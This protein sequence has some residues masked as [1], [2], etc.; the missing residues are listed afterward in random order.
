MGHAA[1]VMVVIDG[2][3]YVAIPEKDYVRMTGKSDP[4]E[5]AVDAVAFTRKAI[6]DDLRA[7][8][9]AAG[10]TQQQLAK[11]LRKTQPM[12]SGAETG[13][14]RVGLKYVQAVLRACGLPDDWKAPPR[15]KAVGRRPRREVVEFP[16]TARRT[17]RRRRARAPRFAA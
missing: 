17:P 5:G 16:R 15:A 7:A 2:E 9:E 8:R 10:L 3:A 1:K 6:G 14:V 13:A 11:K 4:H 12:V